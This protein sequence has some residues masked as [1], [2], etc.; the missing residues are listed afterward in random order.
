MRDEDGNVVTPMDDRTPKERELARYLVHLVESHGITDLAGDP[1][2]WQCD[3]FKAVI[4][5]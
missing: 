2:C 1:S 4:N 3:N 5:A